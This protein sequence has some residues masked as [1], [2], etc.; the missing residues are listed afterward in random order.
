MLRAATNPQYSLT[1]LASLPVHQSFLLRIDI[2]VLT[3][4]EQNGQGGDK[5]KL[6]GRTARESPD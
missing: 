1:G 6:G 2:S 4:A 3:R 5:D